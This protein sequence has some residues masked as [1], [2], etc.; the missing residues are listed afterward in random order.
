LCPFGFNGLPEILWRCSRDFGR[1][2]IGLAVR[3]RTPALGDS[4]IVD[5]DRGIQSAVG[6]VGPVVGDGPPIG[7]RVGTGILEP[8]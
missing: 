6:E 1:D 3:P 7:A 4:V 5:V 2:A 8:A